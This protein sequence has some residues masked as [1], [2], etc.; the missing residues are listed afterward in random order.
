MPSE[1]VGK[2]LDALM[3]TWPA[4]L[5]KGAYSAVTLP[6]DV[7]QGNVSMYGPDGHTNPEVINRSA[8]LAGLVMGGGVPM[9]ETGALGMAGG[10]IGAPEARR[11]LPSSSSLETPPAP[12]VEDMIRAARMESVSLAQAR[13][14]QPKMQWDRFNAGDHPPPMLEQ[15]ADKPVAVRRED[16]EYLIFDGH[17]RT[18]NALNDGLDKM[19]MH[20]I[21][22]KD[23]APEFAGRA[24][25]PETMSIDDILDAL[26]GK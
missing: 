9:A 8:D 26:L 6:G 13:G 11:Y 10:K 14:T 23:Y 25:A 5:A 15:Y 20:V 1:G 17:H 19:D 3:Q 22:A 16:G 12:T 18:V 4:R 7:Y 21:D 2:V 24:P